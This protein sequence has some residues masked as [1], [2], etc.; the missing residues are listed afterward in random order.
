M[1]DII[2]QNTEPLFIFDMP[3]DETLSE[4]ISVK[5]EKGERGDPTKTSQLI[6]DSDYTTNAALTAGLATKANKDAYE[7]TAAQ[8]AANTE[9]LNDI[10]SEY[11]GF[12]ANATSPRWYKLVSFPV[13]GVNDANDATCFIRG[14]IGAATAANSAFVD[15][16][17]RN[18][19]SVEVV[20]DYFT[21]DDDNTATDIVIYE[22]NDQKA[23]AYLLCKNGWS[24][25][26]LSIVKRAQCTQDFDETYVTTEP[27]GTLVWSLLDNRGSVQKN[28]GG[29]ISASIDG[30]AATVNGHTVDADVPVGAVFTDTIYDDT[31]IK[32]DI[33]LKANT[34]DVASTYTTKTEAQ[35]ITSMIESIANGSPLVADDISE[36]TDTSRIYVLT[37]DG[38]WYFYDGG[39]WTDGGVYQATGLSD[40][41]VTHSKIAS[42]IVPAIAGGNLVDWRE[43]V[44]GYMGNDGVFHPNATSST[45]LKYC[46]PFIP[47]DSSVTTLYARGCKAAIQCFDASKTH[48]GRASDS[49]ALDYITFTL[50]SGTAYIR[51]NVGAVVGTQDTY[52]KTLAYCGVTNASMPFLYSIDDLYERSASRVVYRLGG[53]YGQGAGGGIYH[54][55]VNHKII[56][57]NCTY[58][59]VY[60]N[61]TWYILLAA[62][63]TPQDF[64]LYDYGSA[65]GVIR[66]WFDTETGTLSHTSSAAAAKSV[67][68]SNIFIAEINGYNCHVAGIGELSQFLNVKAY[69][70]PYNSADA[71]TTTSGSNN[72]IVV[73]FPVGS[74]YLLKDNLAYDRKEIGG[75]PT[76]EAAS[77]TLASS[78]ALVLNINDWSLSVV[79]YAE[80]RNTFATSPKN[81][82]LL[83]NVQGKL[84][85]GEL[86]PQLHQEKIDALMAASRGDEDIDGMYD[87]Y[88]SA[89]MPYWPSDFTFVGDELWAFE[90]SS[91]DHSSY[92]NIRR[93][94]LDLVNKSLTYIGAIQ[95]NFGHCNT[96]DYCAEN[97]TLIL[98]NGGGSGNTEPDQIYI[99]E[100]VSTLKNSSQWALSQVAKVIDLDAVG[101]DWGKQIN[102]CWG[103]GNRGDYNT[104]Y[105]LSNDG[106]NK[107]VHEIVLGKGANA[108]TYGTAVP[109]SDD[110]FNATMAVVNSY[111]GNY[112]VTG[113][114]V[115]Q[116]SQFYKGEL[117]EAVG[118]TGVWIHQSKLLTNGTIIWESHQEKTRDASGAVVASYAEGCCIKDGYLITTA[119]ISGQSSTLLVY[120]I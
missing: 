45:G 30:D 13:K 25:V 16:M 2:N 83:V 92:S 114:P 119:N 5:G 78:S 102:V 24:V 94:S 112:A 97:D 14:K 72:A 27:S 87:Y 43:L 64:T 84:V 22:D 115:N 75:Y 105:V 73:N 95:H 34:A 108:L 77:Y 66:I 37:T 59:G 51:I 57:Q 61:R 117:W 96:V 65:T 111:T 104:A 74:W 19:T 50:T 62:T 55:P 60:S 86:L 8:V 20:G 71:I 58:C 54:D 4:T 103:N 44:D 12:S 42:N 89:N 99:I 1:S 101:L 88:M 23:H 41:S 52:D 9:A 33:E 38:H 31:V 26:Q 70:R 48:I 120:K 118:H 98:G 21:G 17:M 81:I 28:K 107:F 39:S 100:N 110:Q 63:N 6:N 32:A 7:A 80:R 35:Q 3:D 18:R 90:V 113:S 116:G 91:D 11:V 36:M 56:I 69:F 109:A 46:T 15:L 49:W 10:A 85:S 79:P 47:V 67:A 82:I 93:F 106:T 76:H 53:S 40:D 68:N 29:T